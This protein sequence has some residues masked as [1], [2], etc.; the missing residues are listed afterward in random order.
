MR[1]INKVILVSMLI[2]IFSTFPVI[3]I[4]DQKYKDIENMIESFRI[5]LMKH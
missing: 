5:H 2:S 4:D 1:L 3:A